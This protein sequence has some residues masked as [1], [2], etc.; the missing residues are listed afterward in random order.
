[1]FGNLYNKLFKGGGK[2]S[3]PRTAD[4]L[5]VPTVLGS[6]RPAR[7]VPTLPEWHPGDVIMER[8]QV[9]EVLSGAMGRVYIC[10]HLGWGIKMAIKSPRAEVLEDHEGM[11]RIL[12]EANG[13]IRMGMHPN[14]AACYYVLAIERVPHL[15][16][17]YVDGGS[18]ADWIKAGRCRDLR[19]ALSLA[20]Q[21]CHGMEYTHGRG[22]IHRDIKPANILVTKNALLK[23]TDFGILLKAS[24][25]KANGRGRAK[26][27]S[28]DGGGDTDLTVGFRGTP[29]FASPEQ[30]RD[31]HNVDLRTDIYSFGL[32]LWLMLCERKP[33]VKN[34]VRQIIP[35]PVPAAANLS[36]PLPGPRLEAFRCL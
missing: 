15:F 12:K 6:G 3:S 33:F 29:G 8:Y 27:L 10:E 13:W 17:E 25:R 18:L 4:D 5:D 30:F 1:M 28:V 21:C 22:I 20:V 34:S 9:E 16:I 2:A 26:Q 24:D 19:T 11:Q 32:C 7:K 36:F 23:I 35:E 14:I 31:A